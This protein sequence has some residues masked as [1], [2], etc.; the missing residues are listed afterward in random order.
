[1]KLSASIR[2]SQV[3]Q[4][5]KTSLLGASSRDVAESLSE[6]SKGRFDVARI[7]QQRGDYQH[8]SAGYRGLSPRPIL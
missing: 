6:G 4:T 7:S 5:L 1:M 3:A 2:R 8:N